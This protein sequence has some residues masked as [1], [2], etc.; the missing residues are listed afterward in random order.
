MLTYGLALGRPM[1]GGHI[2]PVLRTLTA[3]G[4]ADVGY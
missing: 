1:E 2:V 4:K 3:M